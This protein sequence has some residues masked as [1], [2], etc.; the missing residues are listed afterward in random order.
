M[1][2]FTAAALTAAIGILFMIPQEAAAAKPAVAMAAVKN[3]S[4]NKTVTMEAFVPAVQHQLVVSGKFDVCDMSMLGEM[5]RARIADFP[6]S[7]EALDV[8]RPGYLVRMEVMQYSVMSSAVR[9]QQENI[10]ATRTEAKIAANLIYCDAL[11]GQVLFSEQAS[12]I[13]TFA[14]QGGISSAATGNYA[15]KVLA[16]AIQSI[17]RQTVDKLME[18]IYPIKIIKAGAGG[19]IV[20]AG[21]DRL[22]AGEF[23]NA[24]TAGEELI[25]PDTGEN[26]GSEETWTAQLQVQQVKPRVSTLLQISGALPANCSK[27]I[28]R[29]CVTEQI[30]APAAPPVIPGSSRTTPF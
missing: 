22:K 4:E 20:N 30:L 11:T 18:R 21:E 2:K 13:K 7:A 16:E 6:G 17:A 24:Y 5:A 26:L 27:V 15:E 23:L 10:R 28:L 8:I 14:E 1:L 25:D 9:S 29:K 3:C 12:A 19:I